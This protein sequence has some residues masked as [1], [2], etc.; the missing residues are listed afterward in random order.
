MKRVNIRIKILKAFS[1]LG[2]PAVLERLQSVGLPIQK[3]LQA[4]WGQQN[5]RAKGK[6]KVF[7]FFPIWNL[8]SVFI[9]LFIYFPFPFFSDVC[10]VLDIGGSACT[11]SAFIFHERIHASTHMSS[12]FSFP[13]EQILEWNISYLSPI[14]SSRLISQVCDIVLVIIFFLPS[15]LYDFS[16]IS[17]LFQESSAIVLIL[18]VIFPLL[19]YLFFWKIKRESFNTLSN[20]FKYFRSV[21]HP[22]K[23]IFFNGCCWLLHLMLVYC[24]MFNL[25]L[26]L[27]YLIYC[28][29]WCFIL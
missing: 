2:W 19:R 14:N 20:T 22:H 10:D 11:Y 3:A 28:S 16:I 12:R 24:I 17:S 8:E 23:W 7:I 25:K 9:F 27:S 15:F 13:C 1:G 29:L 5:S 6:E 26:M 21:N 18:R 4:Y